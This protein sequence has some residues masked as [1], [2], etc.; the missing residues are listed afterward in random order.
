MVKLLK[1]GVHFFIIFDRTFS[2]TGGAF[3]YTGGFFL[4]LVALFQ[5]MGAFFMVL[6][7]LFKVKATF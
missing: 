2:D 7:T 5:Y 3:E 4:D 1:V 6:V